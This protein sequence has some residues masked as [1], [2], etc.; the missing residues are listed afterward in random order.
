MRRVVSTGRR[1]S[2]VGRPADRAIGGASNVDTSAGAPTGRACGACGVP[3]S[4]GTVAKGTLSRPLRGQSSGSVAVM[5]APAVSWHAPDAR[6]LG[7]VPTQSA[8]HKASA[9]GAIPRRR[10][11]GR[12][13]GR[14]TGTLCRGEGKDAATGRVP[15]NGG[16]RASP[17]RE[18]IDAANFSASPGDSSGWPRASRSWSGHL[19][20]AW[21]AAPRRPPSRPARQGARPRARAAR[22][23]RRAGTRSRSGA[24]RRAAGTHRTRAGRACRPH[25]GA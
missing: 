6:P 4:S 23:R 1:S 13:K 8:R 5:A 25:A 11:S 15:A 24:G 7:I 3:L 12:I 16:N 19:S 9:V 20:P 21:P 18:P 14:N 2:A 17:S 22:A 10:T